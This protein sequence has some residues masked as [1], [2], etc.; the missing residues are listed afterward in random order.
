M[1]LRPID[2]VSLRRRLDEGS[3]T[4]IDIREP[5]EYAREHI[6]G[7]RLVPVSSLDAHEFS[8]EDGKAVVFQCRSGSRTSAHA[9]R[10]AARAA[11]ECYMLAGGLD[12]WKAAGLPVDLDRT[13]PIDL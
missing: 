6:P 5:D 9:A 10:L 7:A 13:A 1:S 8:R 3:A 4:L 11:T 2:A 12:A